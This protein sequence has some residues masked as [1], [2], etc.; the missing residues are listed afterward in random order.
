MV[1]IRLK[2]VQAVAY[3]NDDLSID[4][5]FVDDMTDEQMAVVLNSR[6]VI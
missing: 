3:L 1:E 4:S 2:S 5:E 6:V